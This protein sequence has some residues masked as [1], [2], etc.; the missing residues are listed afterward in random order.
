MGLDKRNENSLL[1]AFST[2]A[3][4]SPALG[5]HSSPVLL[6]FFLCDVSIPW[7][8]VEWRFSSILLELCYD[9]DLA[10]S[11]DPKELVLTLV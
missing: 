7:R 6:F 1:Y 9:G 5:F 8:G 11:V 10:A 2:R 4:I 3:M